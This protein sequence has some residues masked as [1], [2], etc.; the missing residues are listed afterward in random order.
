M[1]LILRHPFY[2]MASIT[3]VA[4][5][6]FINFI[7][8]LIILAVSV[9]WRQRWIASA[10][11]SHKRTF[12]L[13]ILISVLFWS[14]AILM[15]V[16][17][18]DVFPSINEDQ[19]LA[20]VTTCMMFIF[21]LWISM[22][23]TTEWAIEVPNTLPVDRSFVSVRKGIVMTIVVF[24]ALGLVIIITPLHEIT[25]I[26]VIAMCGTIIAMF[27]SY[28]ASSFERIGAFMIIAAISLIWVLTIAVWYGIDIPSLPSWLYGVILSTFGVFGGATGRRPKALL[29]YCKHHQHDARCRTIFTARHE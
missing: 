7:P 13:G 8:L 2:N 23:H 21:I 27:G 9:Y 24:S 6:F 22:S 25:M 14:F 1:F 12:M 19:D 5:I 26:I 29:E 11:R 17:I 15:A 3:D 10:I 18:V 16:G 4:I 28:T 20:W